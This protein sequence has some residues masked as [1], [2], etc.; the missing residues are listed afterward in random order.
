MQGG[1]I[2]LS[3]L[4]LTRTIYLVIQ[5][6]L[7][8]DIFSHNPENVFIERVGEKPIYPCGRVAHGYEG[9]D[10]S[11]LEWAAKEGHFWFSGPI[12]SLRIVMDKGPIQGDL[13]LEPNKMFFITSLNRLN[14]KNFEA[15]VERLKQSAQDLKFELDFQSIRINVVKL[16]VTFKMPLSVKNV[17]DFVTKLHVLYQSTNRL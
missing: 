2:V 17:D 6:L 16:V 15:V 14:Y 8:R 12:K 10:L 1:L 4:D 13:E 7:K 9:L 5:S 11:Q 3:D